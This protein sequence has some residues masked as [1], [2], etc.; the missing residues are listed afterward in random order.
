M[1]LT[2]FTIYKI[3]KIILNRKNH[4]IEY[5]LKNLKMILDKI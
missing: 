3:I 5:F 4:L 1:K 2:N